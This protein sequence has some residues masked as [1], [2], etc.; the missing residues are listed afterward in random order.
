ME[1]NYTLAATAL[2]PVLGVMV[3]VASA[4]VSAICMFKIV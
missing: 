2:L 3:P 1:N 4:S